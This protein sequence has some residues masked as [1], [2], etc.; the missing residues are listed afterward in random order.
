MKKY[1][2]AKKFY[3]EALVHKNNDPYAKTKMIECQKLMSA[4]NSVSAQNRRKDLLANYKPGVTEETLKGP[5]VTILQRVVVKESEVW[6][7]QKKMFDWGGVT[8]FRDN[9]AITELIFEQET[10]P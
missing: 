3:E 10:K 1:K 2:D 5:G 8:F 6:V 4:D 7:Y 9:D